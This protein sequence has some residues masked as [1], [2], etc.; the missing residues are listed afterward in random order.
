MS[1]IKDLGCAPAS[2][3]GSNAEVSQKSL[4]LSLKRLGVDDTRVHYMDIKSRLAS[5]SWT[6][7][8]VS[9]NRLI[10]V[11]QTTL[12]LNDLAAEVKR[13]VVRGCVVS[14][15]SPMVA[16]PSGGGSIVPG[17]NM[18]KAMRLAFLH[19]ICFYVISVFLLGMVDP[20]NSA[21]LAFVTIARGG[22]AVLSIAAVRDILFAGAIDESQASPSLG[23]KDMLGQSLPIPHQLELG[24]EVMQL[25]KYHDATLLDGLITEGKV[26]IE[27]SPQ[28]I[29]SLYAGGLILGDGC[30]LVIVLVTGYDIV[31][32]TV[33][34]IIGD[35]IADIWDLDDEGELNAV[36][37]AAEWTGRLLVYGGKLGA[38]P[39][40]LENTSF[41][42]QDCRL[43]IQYYTAKAIVGD[44]FTHA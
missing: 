33:R 24:A 22:T 5:P 40:I 13:P 1:R 8:G 44:K 4:V 32:T 18:V 17:L 30:R 31:R 41:A 43:N 28:S 16:T 36:H 25:V 7:S 20:H 15:L 19:I 6:N 42:D 10:H 21:D 39:A 14:P 27:S 2:S 29:K 38:I 9:S 37:M 26:K 3:G 34:K 35:T 12:T 23:T 11:S